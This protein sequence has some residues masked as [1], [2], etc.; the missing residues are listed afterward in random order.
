MPMDD[1]KQMDRVQKIPISELVPFKD[2][3]FKVVEDE[4]MLR[5]TESI[6]MFGVLTP[7]IARPTEDG[8]YEIIFGRPGR[9]HAD[10]LRM[11]RLHDH[12]AH[13]EFHGHPDCDGSISG[14]DHCRCQVNRRNTSDCWRIPW[15]VHTFITRIYCLGNISDGNASK[16][17]L[18]LYTV[19][20]FMPHR[21]LR[22]R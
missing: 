13:M 7:L 1:E 14:T 2:H 9:S 18:I 10:H 16:C 6:S 12:S 5:T 17:S 21:H 19:F 20:F 22:L 11:H 4:S 8:K 3:P 15:G